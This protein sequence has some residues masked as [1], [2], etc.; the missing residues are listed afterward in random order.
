MLSITFDPKTFRLGRLCKR[1]HNWKSTGKSLRYISTGDCIECLDFRYKQK[2]YGEQGQELLQKRRLLYRKNREQVLTQQK[3][4]RENNP[5]LARGKARKQRENRTPKQRENYLSYLK[6]YYQQNREA[7]NEKARQY[8]EANPEK[9]KESGR[10]YRQL[11]YLKIREHQSKNRRFRL[12]CHRAAYSFE[13]VQQLR[14]SFDWQCAYCGSGE[15]TSLDHFIP[16]SKGGP[17]CIGNLLPCCLSC[18]HKKQDSDALDWYQKT[19]F[20]SPKRWK[21]IKKVLGKS[22]ASQGQLPLF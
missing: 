16:M 1:G 9:L 11:N 19:P 14:E 5:E 22:I 7:M 8:R 12:S 3:Q 6:A 21:K 18:N 15:A 20:Y 4:W 17:D 2:R 13:Q 10:R